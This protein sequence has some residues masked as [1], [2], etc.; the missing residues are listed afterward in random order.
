MMHSDWLSIFIGLYFRQEFIAHSN[1]SHG[2]WSVPPCTG[3]S[4]SIFDKGRHYDEFVP[5]RRMSCIVTEVRVALPIPA[6]D[7]I[8]VEDRNHGLA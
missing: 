4:F 7:E 6:T 8:H 1:A 5:S 2:V 3:S